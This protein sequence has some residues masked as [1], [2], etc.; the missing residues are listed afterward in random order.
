MQPIGEFRSGVMQ[1]KQLLVE[2]T[3]QPRQFLCIAQLFCFGDL[4]VL[5]SKTCVVKVHGNT[6]RIIGHRH[7]CLIRVSLSRRVVHVRLGVHLNCSGVAVGTFIAP[8]LVIQHNVLRAEIR[9]RVLSF[10]NG[11]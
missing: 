10:V 4:V 1:G 5:L 3:A 2:Q 11:F 8:G 7:R 6:T 9:F